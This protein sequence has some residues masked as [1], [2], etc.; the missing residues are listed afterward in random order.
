MMKMSMEQYQKRFPRWVMCNQ[1]H[2]VFKDHT[3]LIKHLKKK[4]A[5]CKFV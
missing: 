1:C 2:K 5:T 3:A 4:N